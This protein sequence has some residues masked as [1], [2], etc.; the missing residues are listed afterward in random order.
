MNVNYLL[1]LIWPPTCQLCDSP[2]TSPD[3]D[4]FCFSCWRA[5]IDR[6]AGPCCPRCG[7]SRPAGCAPGPCAEC[8]RRVRVWRTARHGAVYAGPIREAIRRYKYGG[9][10]AM[11]RPLARL[12]RRAA[13]ALPVRW[14]RIGGLLPVPMDPW[15]RLRR[16]YNPP[17]LLARALAQQLGVPLLSGLLRGKR[18]PR[19]ARL[20]RAARQE[21]ARRRFVAGRA[22]PPP[23]VILIDD[24]WTTGATSAACARLLRSRGAKVVY[25]LTAARR[26]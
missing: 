15:R 26:I 20:S 5:C 22:T 10:T 23:E 17:E 8:R 19:Q 3:R 14:D 7:L 6:S 16:G 24:V 21:N 13:Q 11:A 9:E 2:L 4:V 1:D 25:L 12:L 18:G